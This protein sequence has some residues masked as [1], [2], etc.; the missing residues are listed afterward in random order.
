MIHALLPA[1]LA[2]AAMLIQDQVGTV[3]VKLEA[4][5]NGWLAGVMDAI[6]YLFGILT[7]NT[8]LTTLSSGNLDSTILVLSLVTVA[9]VV[10]TK[11][12]QVEGRWLLN[13]HHRKRVVA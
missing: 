2:A 11:A 12:G 5:D 8:A 7:L 9:N 4:G 10:G 6:G 13:R 3:M 1:L